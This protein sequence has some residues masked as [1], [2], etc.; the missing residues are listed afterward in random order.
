MAL[1]FLAGCIG[2]C[3]GVLVGHPLDTVK[4]HL[5][6]QDPK[7]PKY[8][9]T[10]HCIRTIVAQD[11][12]SGLY[13]GITSPMGG[14]G[15]VNAIVF[16]V[17][18]N[19]Q[20]SRTDPDSLA[21]HALAGGVA[22]LFQSIVCAPM[23]LAKTR[24]QLQSESSPGQKFKGPVQYL[25]HIVR[26]E[27]L[28][29]TMRGLTFT[30]FRDVPGFA[31]YFVSYEFMMRQQS[32]PN[33]VYGLC[34]GGLAGICSWLAT[35]PIDVVKTCIQADDLKHPKYNGY[36]DCIRK[37]YES[38]G[39][40]FFFRGM[41]STL[42]RS[43]PMNAACFFVVS[44]IM[45]WTKKRDVDVV[46]HT[47][48]A[49][50]L[51]SVATSTPLC[52]I[53]HIDRTEDQLRHRRSLLAQSLRSFGAFNEAVCHSETQE[54]ATEFYPDKEKYYIFEDERLLHRA[55]EPIQF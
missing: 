8:N 32:Q 28:R 48:D 31:S 23:E 47:G 45:N 11:K 41:N 5:Q 52:H 2:G 25:R 22:G 6:T 46:V 10:W 54:L 1:D 19:V 38:D 42:I 53:P 36:M 24:L 13:R 43:F 30:A 39:I 4:V 18:G 49:V 33:I 9:G 3:A 20:R 40:R 50:A 16:G 21:S 27:G 34:A 14:V 17:Y 29:G 35:Y 26:H 7:S 37:G 15:F 51:V 44:W 55:D 12:I